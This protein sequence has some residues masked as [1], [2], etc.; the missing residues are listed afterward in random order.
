MIR[1]EYELALKAALGAEDVGHSGG[2]TLF[3]HLRGTYDLLDQ[4]GAAEHVKVAGLFHSIYGTNTFRHQCLQPTAKNRELV[5]KLI[6]PKA[7]HLVYLFCTS[8]RPRF[9]AE[10]QDLKELRLI[11]K[12]NLQEQAPG[13][14]ASKVAEGS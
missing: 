14:L 13:H 12:A 6:G 1:L 11:E 8:N 7:E 10:G 9:N 2:R 3:T 5:A 4:W